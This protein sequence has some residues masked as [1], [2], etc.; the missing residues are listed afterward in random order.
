MLTEKQIFVFDNFTKQNMYSINVEEFQFL[1]VIF[2]K[3]DLV[4]IND[5][6]GI[7]YFH[8]DASHAKFKVVGGVLTTAAPPQG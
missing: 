7:Y 5:D 1:K 6:H 8:E 4:A 2:F 3:E